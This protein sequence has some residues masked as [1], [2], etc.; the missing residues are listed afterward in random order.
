M[1]FILVIF[2]F[3]YPYGLILNQRKV[4]F[5]GEDGC[6]TESPKKARFLVKSA[7]LIGSLIFGF[8]LILGILGFFN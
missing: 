1:E 3:S 4:I 2:C 5:W 8:S 6:L 7:A